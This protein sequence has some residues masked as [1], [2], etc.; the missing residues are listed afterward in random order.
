MGWVSL[1]EDKI[2]RYTSE[3]HNIKS[4]LTA[5]SASDN[6]GSNDDRRLQELVSAVDGLL[7]LIRENLDLATSPEMDWVFELTQL[8]KENEELKQQVIY[9]GKKA[10]ENNKAKRAGAFLPLRNESSSIPSPTSRPDK[11]SRPSQQQKPSN[12]SKL[13]A[14]DYC[15]ANIKKSNY[16]NHIKKVH[17]D[18]LAKAMTMATPNLQNSNAPS[19]IHKP[20]L[21]S[22]GP[23]NGIKLIELRRADHEKER[24][25][26]PSG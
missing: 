25:A 26:N 5:H 10:L 13:V 8:K 9:L 4:S 18:K 19:V 12:Q 6:S 16:T 22:I 1:L 3:L 2:D 11:R 14:C 23:F 24:H 17:P 15:R 20:I 7:R 21:S